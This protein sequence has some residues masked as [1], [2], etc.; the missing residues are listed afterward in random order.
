MNTAYEGLCS[1]LLRQ[2][3]SDKRLKNDL[4]KPNKTYRVATLNCRTLRTFVAKTELSKLMSDFDISVMCIQEHRIIHSLTD[5][6]IVVH[7]LGNSTLFTVSASRNERGAS[8]HGVGIAVKTSLLQLISSVKRVSDRILSVTFK[9]NPKTTII[10]CYAPHNATEED[11]ANNFYACLDNTVESV[12]SQNMLIVA[13]DFNAQLSEGFS[14]H[15]S[16]NR[17]GELLT[18]FTQSHNLIVG[19]TN[20]QKPRTKLWTQIT[21][22]RPLSN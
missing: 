1:N 16:C 3:K 14:L 18:N 10:S 12:P 22:R 7:N 20:F 6:D 11:I 15:T 2:Q 4:S 5:P 9:G 13:G 17:N 21:K 8:I 19:N